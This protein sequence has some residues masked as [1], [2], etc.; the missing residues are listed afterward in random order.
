M[1]SSTHKKYRS[2]KKNEDKDGKAMLSNE[3]WCIQQ[4]NGKLEKQN[5][6]KTCKQ[7]KRLFQMNIKIKL[8]V[9]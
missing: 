2:K 8:H 3:Q 1:L 7:Q 5:S 4:N 9:T 6:C